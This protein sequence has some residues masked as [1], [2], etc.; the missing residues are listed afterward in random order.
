MPVMFT[1]VP[2]AGGMPQRLSPRCKSRAVDDDHR[3]AV[4]RRSTRLVRLPPT[5][6][7]GRADS[8]GRRRER[9]RRSRRRRSIP[10]P[11]C[12][13]APGQERRGRR[14]PGCRR[15]HR[16]RTARGP[17]APP[18]NA[19]PTCWLGRERGGAGA[20]GRG[21]GAG[22]RPPAGQLRRRRRARRSGRR[23]ASRRRP[24]RRVEQRLQ[25]GAAD[26]TDWADHDRQPSI[27]P[28]IRTDQGA[29]TNNLVTDNLCRTARGFAP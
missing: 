18:R 6:R 4:A 19:R 29:T 5:P 14:A 21:R 9:A 10:V 25:T 24:H 3:A 13:R 1:T 28:R 11:T 7:F 23:T 12:G 26:D 20:G 22:R 15:D 27:R 2:P 8:R 16:P 17:D